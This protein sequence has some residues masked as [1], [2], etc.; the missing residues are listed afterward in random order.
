[1][2]ALPE[3][4]IVSSAF[5]PKNWMHFYRSIGENAASFEMIFVGP[6]APD[7]ELP[8]NFRFIHS[9]VK[10]V[11]CFEIGIR[12]SRADYVLYW[13][14]DYEFRT[15]RPLDKLVS[16]F[17]TIGNPGV[18]ISCRYML[19]GTDQSGFAHR[20]FVGDANSPIMPACGFMLREYLTNLGGIDKNFT[21]IMWDCDLAMRYFESGGNVVLCDVFLNEDRS[22]SEGS[23]LCDEHWNIDRRLLE[24]LWVS[25]GQIRRTRAKVVEPFE[26]KDILTVSQGPRGRWQ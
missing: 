26:D 10:P 2:T 8:N 13:A 17:K 5:R 18:M 7:F 15:E 24:S 3:I 14:D 1:M 25:D 12:E 21:A 19:N 20:F 11:Q 4:S 23:R 22:K 16:E 6:N 9:N